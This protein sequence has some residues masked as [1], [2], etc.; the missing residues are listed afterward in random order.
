MGADE[1]GSYRQALAVSGGRHVFVP[2]RYRAGDG[3]SWDVRAVDAKQAVARP[4][5]GHAL[6][7]RVGA[8]VLSGLAGGARFGVI[9]QVSGALVMVAKLVDGQDRWELSG[10]KGRC[11]AEPASLR[12]ARNSGRYRRGTPTQ[13]Q[14]NG[15]SSGESFPR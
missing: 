5:L 7:Y 4:W 11:R 8:G 14:R 15:A 1:G 13:T 6:V 9:M 3:S 12:S 2:I 10:G